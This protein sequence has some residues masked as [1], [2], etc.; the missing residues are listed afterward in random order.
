MK[1]K[2]I[3]SEDLSIIII[4]MEEV[5]IVMTQKYSSFGSER[6]YFTA[7][8]IDRMFEHDSMK[9][10]DIFEISN[11]SYEIIDKYI[12]LRFVIIKR[13]SEFD[14]DIFYTNIRILVNRV[15]PILPIRHIKI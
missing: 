9:N 3:E 6:S 1:R 15:D 2:D 5:C 13:S 10:L 12:D 14:S 8:V 11:L 7:K 4:N